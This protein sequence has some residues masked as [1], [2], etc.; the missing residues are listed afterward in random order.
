[1]LTYLD[2]NRFVLEY[3]YKLGISIVGYIKGGTVYEF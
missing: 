1:M 3:D 2:V